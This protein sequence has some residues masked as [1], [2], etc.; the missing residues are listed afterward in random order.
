MRNE[1]EK[2]IF[3][4][5]IY[6]TTVSIPANVVDQYCNKQLLNYL[7]AQVIS[8]LVNSYT[9]QID[10]LFIDALGKRGKNGTKFE[11]QL[12]IQNTNINLI[13]ENKADIK[14]PVV[15][16]ASIL[17]K[18]ERDRQ[19]TF[20]EQTWGKLGCGYSNDKDTLSFLKNIYHTKKS[21]PHFVR[22]S[23]TT[24]SHITEGKQKDF[25]STI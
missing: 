14:Y 23:W 8:S 7:E 19:L 24:I 2:Q 5:S 18:V 12:S 17:A 16:A 13:I 15:S 6:A 3:N 21:F 25:F 4:I 22:Q 20:L 1:L 9:K 11:K 10:T